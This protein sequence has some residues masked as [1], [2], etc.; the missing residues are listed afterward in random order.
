MSILRLEGLSLRIGAKPI[1]H[2]ISFDIEPG[3]VLGLVGASGSGKSLCALS[4]ARLLPPQSELDGRIYF[5]G[6]NLSVADEARLN[7]VR[8]NE[9]GVI[10][11]EPM[12]ALNPLMSIGAQIAESF[13]I[14]RKMR[15]ALA[16]DEAV[17]AL[18]R[19]G[20]DPSVI[21]P[22][23][24]PHELS[25]G[26][27]QRVVIAMAGALRPKL[28]IADEPTT[29]LDLLTQGKIVD[30][31]KDFAKTNQA[32]VLFI[33]HDLALI[34][35]I[36][37]RVMVMSE[38]RI[39]E[40]G[41]KDAI[42]GAPQ[43]EK[44]RALVDA[45]RF[46]PRRKSRSKKKTGDR[47]EQGGKTRKAPVLVAKDI[48]LSYAR[49]PFWG[50]RA[51]KVR[52]PALDHISLKLA[53]GEIAALIGASGA[54][55]SSVMRTLL[56]FEPGASGQISICGEE[57]SNKHYPPAARRQIQAVFQDPISSFNPRHQV[58][59]IIGEPLFLLKERISVEERARR[60]G[61]VLEAVGLNGGDA[62]R[63]IGEFSGGERQR[64][65]IARA[66]IV[67]PQII[68]LDEALSAVDLALRGHILQLLIDLADERQLSYLFITH[69]LS[70]LPG[71]ADHVF[72]MEKGRIV[73]SGKTGA[74]FKSPKQKYTRELLSGVLPFP[75][76]P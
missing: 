2:D 50:A 43:H 25:G 53:R 21:S 38:G 58:G 57:V 46:R 5:D 4:I 49:K 10:F 65:A 73:E 12:S 56:G 11:Q 30:H 31:I 45:A 39:V 33:S 15:P 16:W 60:V 28:L 23:R 37:D 35:A 74:I 52:P 66:L 67:E 69:D 40:A 3:E 51:G 42:F 34:N 70:M 20:L 68:L 17:I 6:E 7:R 19:A 13:M 27:R 72:V 1:L 24:F 29:S 8:G 54:G 9:I 26:E 41:S 55:K 14:H 48:S 32:A 44:T 18:E 59:R 75:K 22:H 63:H 62:T 76:K 47:Q 36:A 71:F 64:I 61:E